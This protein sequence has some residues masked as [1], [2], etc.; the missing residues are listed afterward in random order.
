[1][2]SY[3]DPRSQPHRLRRQLPHLLPVV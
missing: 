2:A 1:M 3:S